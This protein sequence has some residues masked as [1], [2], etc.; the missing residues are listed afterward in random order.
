MAPHVFKEL[1][2]EMDVEI[3]LLNQIENVVEIGLHVMDVVVGVGKCPARR[4]MN[5]V[6]GDLARCLTL[7]IGSKKS[8]RLLLLGIGTGAVGM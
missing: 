3:T 7:R 1:Y 5:T 6:E 2:E 8:A 4:D